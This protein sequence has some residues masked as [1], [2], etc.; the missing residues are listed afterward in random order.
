MRTWVCMLLIFVLLQESALTQ[1]SLLDKKVK[2]EF[3][4]GTIGSILDELG[5]KGGFVF[6]YGQD[7]PHNQQVELKHPYQSVHEHLDD[8]FHESVQC[9]EYGNKVMMKK[10]PQQPEIYTVGGRILDAFTG[11]ALV[12]V[13]ICIPGTDPLIG[14]ISD[15]MGHFKINVPIG[16]DMLRF[17]CMGYEST[18]L[19][20]YKSS[21]TLVEL[22]PGSF[23]IE[24]AVIENFV[25][26]VKGAI[27]I[28]V[29]YISTDVLERIPAPSID[30]LLQGSVPGIHVTRNSGMPG[31][32]LQV[33]IR[34]M[35]SLINSEPVYYLDGIPVQQALI[36]A[37][38]PYDVES[39]EVLKDASATSMYGATAGNGVVLLESRIDTRKS[40][41]ASI[42]YQWG[43]QNVAKTLDLMSTEDFLDYF[44]KV[45]PSD[46][47]FDDLDNLYQ[48]NWQELVFDPGSIQD[49]HF[50]VS[51]GTKKSDFYFSSGYH[52]QTAIIKE[53]ELK[54]YSFMMNADHTIS[55]RWKIGHRMA[56]S[57]MSYQGLKEGA[58]LND[59]NN[60][61]LSSL[62]MLPLIPP[63]DSTPVML[64]QSVDVSNSSDYAELDRN[65]RKNYAILGN[66]YSSLSLLPGLN[67]ESRFGVEILFQDNVSYCR[68]EPNK[69]CSRNNPVISDKYNIMDLAFQFQNSLRYGVDLRG[70]HS[71]SA[72]AGFEYH[73]NN[74]SWIPLSRIFYDQ[75]ME[76]I[77]YRA[78]TELPEKWDRDF[79]NNSLTG[80]VGYSFRNKYSFNL[81]IR[82]DEVGFYRLQELKKLKGLFP[83]FAF[84][85]TF[86]EEKLFLRTSVIQY[87]KLRYA[88]GKAG[89]SP[90]MNYSF[91]SKMMRDLE[92]L[93]A[94]NST[95]NITTSALYRR[96]NEKF[97]WENTAT[98]SVGM[99]LG[100]FGNRLFLSLDYFQSL[101]HMGDSKP[102]DLSLE[103]VGDL[104]QRP[105]Y[106]FGYLPTASVIN[107]GFEWSA[108]YRKKGRSLDWELSF[109][110][111]HLKSKITDIEERS[112]AELNND[113]YDPISVNL[114]GHTAGSFFGY[115]I[116][117]LF[118]E[119]DLD[120]S[121]VWKAQPRAQPG[122]YKY[123]DLNEDDRINQED[124]TILGNPFPDFTF[125]LYSNIEFFGF[126]LSVLLQ[127]IY[128]NDIFN[129]TKLWLFN[130]YGLSNWSSDI[131]NSYRSPVYDDDGN[132]SDPGNTQT[133]L[134][135]WDYYARNKNLRPSD[136]YIED[137]SYLRLKN[138]QLGY[139]LKPELCRKIH[140][141]K[142]RVFICTQN[143]YTF[144][145]YS[146]LDP[147]VGGW[148]IDC[149]NYPQPRT[150][151]AGVNIEF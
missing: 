78:N 4:K 123:I 18:S 85:W 57:H 69:R 144:T 76:E 90:R 84:G 30:H 108:K 137:G 6:S 38:S 117:R 77:K 121:E 51:G 2:L 136:F 107:K 68:V 95:G 41:H 8:I 63:S 71:I 58:F 148:G 28:P 27:N 127:G 141:E 118:K 116:D 13:A 56:L 22:Q 115:Q 125:G 111:T 114:P 52:N 32:S 132:I 113:L 67:F 109:H 80:T 122:D 134:H 106:G 54:R 70:G 53:L 104:Y 25:K 14:S 31:A 59:F 60:P 102:M 66:I 42:Q 74:N 55:E 143:L 36:P 79:T 5:K 64:A 39:I 89:N 26:P 20:P 142:I 126:D 120:N 99:D 87:G 128:G 19:N 94:F 35:H 96:T 46:H 147:E 97:Y 73:H 91:Y 34:G 149:G 65:Q 48:T 21:R 49:I 105:A 98:H 86:S 88:W 24:E 15:E 37:L 110:M 44:H 135:R 100:F 82:R 12:G 33:R 139:T 119:E 130:P 81:G 92:F 11:E 145:R 124:R 146:G 10:K 29:S 47:R 83:S 1:S 45:R 150:Y 7:I 75:N 93:C 112:I 9:V 151:M 131:V 50:S 3:L 103:Y 133:S 23:E 72:T 16:M 129:A 62:C 61:I 101:L 17:S 40:I 43:Q 138:I 140:M